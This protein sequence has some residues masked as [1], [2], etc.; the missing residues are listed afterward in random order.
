MTIDNKAKIIVIWVVA[1]LLIISSI[2]L[3]DNVVNLI[4]GDEYIDIY[5]KEVSNGR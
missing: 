1:M 2:L 5:I 3:L 4:I